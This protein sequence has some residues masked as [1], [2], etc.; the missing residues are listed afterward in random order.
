MVFPV[1]IYGCERWTI[2]KA[3]CWRIDVFGV[4]SV[5]V[6]E[7]TLE[8]PLDCKKIQPDHPK[9][10][11]SWVFI[12]RTDVAA[13]TP[14]LWPPHA[15]CWLIRKYSD[16]GRDCGKERRG[17]R[18]WDDWMASPTRWTWIWVISGSMWWTGRPGMLRFMGSQ[19][20]GHDW[21][22]ELNWTDDKPTA[23][24]I[25]NGEKLQAFPLSQGQD[26]EI[27]SHHFYSTVLEVL[28][29][30]IR[31]EKEVKGIQLEKKFNHHSL[32]MT[33]CYK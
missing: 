13:E 25:L 16:A 17:D 10:D 19:K 32:Q 6:L 33:W 20:V 8:S 26:K 28:A 7:K 22:T 9:W 31:E 27:H 24:I 23:N 4:E 3:E 18:G 5:V 14:I 2:K 12:A 30:E 29:T 15:K 11:K 1:V 21:A